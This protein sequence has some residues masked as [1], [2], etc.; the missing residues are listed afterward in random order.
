[1]KTLETEVLIIIACWL[2]V[3][4]SIAYFKSVTLTSKQE[5]IKEFQ[6]KHAI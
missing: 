1:M 4:H 5:K 2:S 6:A 3:S